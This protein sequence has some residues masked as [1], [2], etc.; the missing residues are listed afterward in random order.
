MLCK[1]MRA[2]SAFCCSSVLPPLTLLTP[3]PS[4]HLLCSTFPSPSTR[5]VQQS[6]IIFFC[7]VCEV[8]NSVESV[9]N[10]LIVLGQNSQDALVSGANVKVVDREKGWFFMFGRRRKPFED[11]RV[12]QKKTIKKKPQG[13]HR[14]AARAAVDHSR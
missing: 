12:L 13:T 11:E 6:D 10:V 9:W 4:L 14:F 3:P 7:S 8:L 1:T 5:E 2:A